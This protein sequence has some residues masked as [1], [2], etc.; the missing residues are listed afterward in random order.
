MDEFWIT[1]ISKI[2]GLQS[3]KRFINC[4]KT[5]TRLIINHTL[6]AWFIQIKRASI[7]LQTKCVVIIL[8][9]VRNLEHLKG[10][11]PMEDNPR[12]YSCFRPNM[13]FSYWHLQ[14]VIP[15]TSKPTSCHQLRTAFTI[16]YFDVNSLKMIF[17]LALEFRPN[18]KKKM[19]FLSWL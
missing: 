8:S 2:V 16:H 18:T 4:N 12:D 5:C 17:L 1:Q 15:I 14:L 7:H 13:L 9:S 3:H 19:I 11:L 6:C 10:C